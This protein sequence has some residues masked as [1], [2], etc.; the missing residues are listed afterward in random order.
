[1]SED[2]NSPP[3]KGDKDKVKDKVPG[4]DRPDQT[5]D[6]DQAP[7]KDL[8]EKFEGKSAE[9]VTKMYT[10][11]EK[12]MGQ[13]SDEVSKARQYL[14][15]RE[16]LSKAVAGSPELYKMMEREINTITGK[17]TAEEPKKDQKG[18][19]EA[20]TTDPQVADLRRAEENRI[21][22]D[23][24]NKYG[25]GKMPKEE[26]SDLMK[27]VTTQLAELYDP[28]GS[29]PMSGILST[30]KLDQLGKALDNSYWL[31]NKDALVDR[32]KVP[33]QDL[34]SIGTISSS[35]SGKSDTTS[36]T[37]RERHTAERLGVSPDKYQKQKAVIFDKK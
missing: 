6:K 3:D 15:E 11:L 28:G 7:L 29:K 26:R 30:I 5:R 32:G 24:Q 14:Q 13:Q 10:E 22:S 36:L 35:S 27:K 12:K 37:D 34:A 23:F 20:G 4:K 16:L 19:E 2:K 9:E 33:N 1:M 17:T 21:I 31:A 8:P 18:S 25:I